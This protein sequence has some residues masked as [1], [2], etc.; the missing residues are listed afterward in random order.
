MNES[1]D[2]RCIINGQELVLCCYTYKLQCKEPRCGFYYLRTFLYHILPLQYGICSEST[3]E[4]SGWQS[5]SEKGATECNLWNWC[6]CSIF[7]E[8][9]SSDG[10]LIAVDYQ[11]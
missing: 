2:I 1:F 9:I 4:L 10:N 3:K 7:D 11:I 8:W 6:S 5:K